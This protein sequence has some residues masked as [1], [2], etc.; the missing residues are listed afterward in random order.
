MAITHAS[1]ETACEAAAT[2][3][4]ASNWADA[5]KQAVLIEIY[6]KSL[7]DLSA[8][9]Q[10]ARY[11]RQGALDLLKQIEELEAADMAAQ[12]KRCNYARFQRIGDE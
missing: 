5:R 10:S 7:P 2:A 6:L 3:I 12:G 4:A 11:G 1:L 9:D 8:R